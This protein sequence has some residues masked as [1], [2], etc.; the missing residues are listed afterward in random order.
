MDP[1]KAAKNLQVIRQLMERPVR[2]STQS[3]MA[4]VLAGC[5]ALTG[6][7][8]DAFVLGRCS[9]GAK[10]VGMG[11]W[12][13]VFLIALAGTLGLTR[14]REIRQGMPF[15]TPAKRKLLLTVLGPF[16]AGVGLTAAIM[17]NSFLTRGFGEWGLIFPCWMLFYGVACWQVSQYSTREIGILGAAFIVAGLGS[18][19]FLQESPYLTMSV[20]FGGYHILYGICVWIRYGG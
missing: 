16:V 15:W 8:A 18:A 7:W 9:P 19:A 4:A 20:T 13:C 6:T 5:V 1:D 12:A 11:L 3:G 14:V 10:L 2:Y 17:C